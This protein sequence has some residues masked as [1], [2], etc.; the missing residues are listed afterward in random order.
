MGFLFL[1]LSAPVD[2]LK[3]TRMWLQEV[4]EN[5]AKES[6]TEDVS[7]AVIMRKAYLKI[8]QWNKAEN[9]PEVIRVMNNMRFL[10]K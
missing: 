8:L 5:V 9:F 4:Y 3:F 10:N 7:T 2:G 1:D 6:P